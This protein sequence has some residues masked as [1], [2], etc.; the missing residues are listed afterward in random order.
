M[1]NK[2]ILVTGAAG[3]VGAH[4]CRRLT[5]ENYE[6]AGL[7]YDKKSAQ[8]NPILKKVVSNGG[9]EN[10]I[11]IHCGD[12]TNVDEIKEIFGRS[13]ADYCVHLAAQ[14]ITIKEGGADAQSPTLKINVEGTKNVLNACISAGI[15]GAVV[16]S[17]GKVYGSN[18]KVLDEDAELKGK[19]H[20][21]QSK[22]MAE[23]IA[24]DFFKTEGIPVVITRASNIYGAGDL[25]YSRI[26]PRTI[27]QL[28][29][30]RA[31][32]IYGK[33]SALRDFIYIDDVTSAYLQILENMGKESV[34]GEAFS[35]ATGKMTSVKDA[36]GKI[37][38]LMGK[39]I[40]PEFPEPDAPEFNDA[41]LSTEKA[42]KLLGWK[43]EYTL[44]KGLKETI[45]WYL[46]RR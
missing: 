45:R 2:K 34:Q 18:N 40:T 6:V 46:E 43:A 32:V 4:L 9:N 33:G 3:F 10:N 17:T 38:A 26:I 44:E 12:I 11:E 1:N 30:N 27:K 5:A 23:E 31:P 35:I 16:A 37:G 14:A 8:D 20:Y 41:I 19:G 25:N 36:V 22:I 29:H 13:G 21:A 28:L 24:Q 39:N 42:E 7:V 15:K